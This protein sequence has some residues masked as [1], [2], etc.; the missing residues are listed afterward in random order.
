MELRRAHHLTYQ[1]GVF[2]NTVTIGRKCCKHFF[3]LR[4]HT[5]EGPEVEG[6]CGCVKGISRML[7][8][9][10]TLLKPCWLRIGTALRHAPKRHTPA[11]KDDSEHN[12]DK[13]KPETYV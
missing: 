12:E 3:F 2:P 1:V 4:V 8:P 7:N 6:H 5:S 13:A 10:V 11:P 9:S